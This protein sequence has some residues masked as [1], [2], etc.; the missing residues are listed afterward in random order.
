MRFRFIHAAD[1]HLGSQFSGVA[2]LPEQLSRRLLNA[3]L[4]AL[5]NIIDLAIDNSVSFLLLAGDV[6]ETATP[7]LRVQ[8]YFVAEIERLHKF[9]IDVF[10]VTGNHDANVLKNFLFPLPDN[11]Y[12]FSTEKT[13]SYNMSYQG[14][15]VWITGISYPEPHINQ[16][17]SKL[18]PEV[19]PNAFNI[20]ILHCEIDGGEKSPYAPVQLSNLIH[21]NYNYWA[22]G[23]VHR[24][25]QLYNHAT[26]N[27]SSIIQYPGVTQGRH[28]VESGTKGCYVVEVGS[29]NIAEVNF[30]QIQ[31]IIWE[32]YPLDLCE[33]KPYQIYDYLN[34]IKAE[35]RCPDKCGKLLLL[36]LTGTT[37]CHQWLQNQDQVAELLQDLREGEATRDA[38]VWIAS[39]IDHTLPEID[40]DELRSQKDFLGELLMYLDELTND[41]SVSIGEI[42][43]LLAPLTKTQGLVLNYSDILNRVKLM[44]VQVFNKGGGE[45]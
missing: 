42:E 1:L 3:S 31:D 41:S 23:H 28:R 20:G 22:L 33:I 17:L 5:S 24:A 8:K 9:G 26:I 30:V 32:N 6:F 7:S 13:Q 18:F 34:Q 14:E 25:D 37:R 19:K 2:Q 4:K 29:H 12:P 44:A 21:K 16:D 35:Q 11:L 40:W 27:G 43:N 36:E 15:N 38:F 39:I 10:M 45:V